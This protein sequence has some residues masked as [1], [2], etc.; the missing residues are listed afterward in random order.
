MQHIVE[1]VWHLRRISL[2]QGFAEIFWLLMGAHMLHIAAQDSPR[3]IG[4][5]IK[6]PMEQAL[7]RKGTVAA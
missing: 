5:S 4:E 6:I 7:A 1:R 2:L 3:R